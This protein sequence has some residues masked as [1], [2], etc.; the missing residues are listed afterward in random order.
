M[1]GTWSM[2]LQVPPTRKCLVQNVNSVPLASCRSAGAHEQRHRRHPQ[3]IGH[4]I[5]LRCC[6]SPGVL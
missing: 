2:P 5:M 3:P 6:G 4:G 1:M